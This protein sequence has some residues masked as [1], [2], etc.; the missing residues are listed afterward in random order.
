[1]MAETRTRKPP[2]SL[3]PDCAVLTSIGTVYLYRLQ[4]QDVRAYAELPST[5]LAVDKFR[6]LLMRV[7]SD[8]ISDRGILDAGPL[9]DERVESLGDDEVERVAEAYLDGT[10]L[11]GYRQEGV[12]ATVAVVR[13]ANEPATKFLDRLLNWHAAA[14]TGRASAEASDTMPPRA[15]R[16]PV[17]SGHILL[18]RR[19]AWIAFAGLAAVGAFAIGA[20]LQH[21]LV[22]HRIQEQQEAVF[23]QVK[24]LNGLVAAQAAQAIHDSSELRRR[25]DA[26]EAALRALPPVAAGKP[27]EAAPKAAAKAPASKSRGRAPT[28]R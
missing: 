6:M 13:N 26:L 4:P 15:A 19:E 23:A 17:S 20:F 2:L 24:Q 9:T 22:A 7:G 18:T 25:L 28:S 12:S 10:S 21:Y 16:K 8:A 1:M 27:H 3:G 5:W 14:R 11:R